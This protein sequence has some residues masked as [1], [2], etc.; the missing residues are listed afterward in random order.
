MASSLASASR[1]SRARASQFWQWLVVSMG[2]LSG[3]MSPLRGWFVLV[4]GFYRQAGPIGPLGSGGLLVGGF[5]LAGF[6]LV[7]FGFHV[8]LGGL[9]DAEAALDQ[10]VLHDGLVAGGDDGFAIDVLNGAN[11]ARE[12]A[13]HEGEDFVQGEFAV[14]GF[15][16]WRAGAKAEFAMGHLEGAA[17]GG[18]F[19][20]VGNGP[21]FGGIGHG[22]DGGLVFD[23]VGV[24]VL[25][26]FGDA[27]VAG[28]E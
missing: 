9:D 5:G 15:D 10:G 3:N 22:G 21:G 6:D 7:E 11:V 1:R 28:G 18:E 13:A 8:E 23:D 24:V 12:V 16:G 4:L 20:G 19:E 27:F 26:D 2:V 14:E 25:G 17:A